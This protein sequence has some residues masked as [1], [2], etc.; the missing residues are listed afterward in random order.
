L[1]SA[2]GVKLFHMLQ[3]GA[4][5]ACRKLKHFTDTTVDQSCKAITYRCCLCGAS[6]NSFQLLPTDEVAQSSGKVDLNDSS[7]ITDNEVGSFSNL[8]YASSFTFISKCKLVVLIV[9][10][11]TG[12]C[13]CFCI[14]QNSVWGTCCIRS[15]SDIEPYEVGYRSSSRTKWCVLVKHLASL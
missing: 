10:L 5:K 9:E 13:S 2:F 1:L 15:T 11:Y 14:F 7:L 3:T 12:M 4:K 6:S 8:T